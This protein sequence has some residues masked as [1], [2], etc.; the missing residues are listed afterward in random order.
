MLK[1]S[2][3]MFICIIVLL[4]SSQFCV[5]LKVCFSR[6]GVVGVVGLVGR[7][8]GDLGWLIVSGV[9]CC[10]CEVFGFVL[11]EVSGIGVGGKVVVM[12]MWI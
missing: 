6:F 7:D 5:V 1:K 12:G 9:V 10:L 2:M 11:V 3:M 8:G 4:F